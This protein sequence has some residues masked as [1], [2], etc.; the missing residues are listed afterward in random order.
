MTNGNIRK[1]PENSII[2]L[3][4]SDVLKKEKIVTN[5]L[6]KTGKGIGFIIVEFN[7]VYDSKKIVSDISSNWSKTLDLFSK[8]ATEKAIKK[9]HI[10]M[11]KDSLDDNSD[12]II[13]NFYFDKSES[14]GDNGSKLESGGYN[15]GSSTCSHSTHNR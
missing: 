1:P 6:A 8:R 15:A 13:D 7:H 5:F 14:D 12:K 9:E 11:I 10:E 4:V 2:V 3:Q